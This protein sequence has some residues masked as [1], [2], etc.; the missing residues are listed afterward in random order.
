MYLAQY[1]YEEPRGREPEKKPKIRKK[2]KFKWA[3]ADIIQTTGL[4]AIP[5]CVPHGLTIEQQEALFVR[6]RIEEIT[7]KITSNEL[8]IDYA[9]ERSPSPEPVYDAQG[10]KVNT[11]EQRAKEKLGQ[12]RQNLIEI[13]MMMNPDFKPPADYSQ[14]QFKKSKKIYVPVDKFPDYNFIG[15]IIGPR[16][17]TQKRMEKE[18]GAKISIRGRGSVKDGKVKGKQPGDDEPLHVFITADTDSQLEKAGKLIR[19]ILTPVDENL[20]RLKHAQ[21]RELAEMNGTLRD[22]S[23]LDPAERSFEMSN[24]KCAICLETSHPTSDCPLRGKGMPVGGIT[25][26]NSSELELEYDKFLAEI[27][28]APALP[29]APPVEDIY[30]EFKAS[31]GDAPAPWQTQGNSAPWSQQSAPWAQQGSAP[32]Q[33]S[34]WQGM[35]NAPWQ[36][37]Q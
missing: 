7:R 29:P 8:D 26:T 2:K 35:Y 15:L 1:P 21:L 25:N 5:K 13:G 19:E 17:N 34:N 31:I 9:A 20:N 33:Q 16:G 28:E 27:G 12:E 3:P 36:Q 24:V 4:S 11:R 30:A 23:W 37:P 18:T 10:K 14:G 32:W 6:I 22:R